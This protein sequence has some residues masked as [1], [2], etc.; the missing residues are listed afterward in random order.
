MRISNL[1]IRLEGRSGI[2]YPYHHKKFM[3]KIEEYAGRFLRLEIFDLD[4][5]I[6]NLQL[7]GAETKTARIKLKT[8]FLSNVQIIQSLTHHFFCPE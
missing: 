5:L 4:F 1:L 6:P 2:E 8:T 7:R 3:E